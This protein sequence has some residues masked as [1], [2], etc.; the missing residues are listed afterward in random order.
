MVNWWQHRC[1]HLAIY[2]DCRMHH[3]SRKDWGWKRKQAQNVE[4]DKAGIKYRPCGQQP[5]RLNDPLVSSRFVCA[6]WGEFRELRRPV[7][8]HCTSQ[9]ESNNFRWL[10]SPKP[11]EHCI[12]KN[13]SQLCPTQPTTEYVLTSSRAPFVES[14]EALRV[15]RRC[16][17]RWG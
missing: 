16:S 12:W 5:Q 7:N 1:E 17:R 10:S 2:R 6:S 14:L 15:V 11:S 4:S 13:W 8:Q 3:M 9:Y